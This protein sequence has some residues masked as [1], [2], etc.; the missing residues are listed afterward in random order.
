MKFTVNDNTYFVKWEYLLDFEGRPY[1]T[2]C[3]VYDN[4]TSY[5]TPI[6]ITGAVCSQQ[7]KFNKNTG[8]KI[9]LDRALKELFPGGNNDRK[10]RA[11]AWAEYF[12]ESPKRLKT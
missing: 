12:K 2:I 10:V 3:R 4:E 11:I 7:D 1:N 6:L 5:N 9:S 8:R